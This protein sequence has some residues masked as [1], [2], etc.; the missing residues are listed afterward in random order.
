MAFSSFL[1]S[2]F[3]ISAD[4]NIYVSK[5]RL[6]DNLVLPLTIALSFIILV[7]FI[8]FYRVIS[9][10]N[11][12]YE[13]AK[14]VVGD[15][16][17]SFGRKMQKHDNRISLAAETVN[18]LSSEEGNIVRKMDQHERR[19]AE[20]ASKA[21]KTLQSRSKMMTEVKAIEEKIRQAVSVQETIEQKIDK[22][23]E[24]HLET[25]R[26]GR[27]IVTPISIKRER[28]LAS[29]TEYQLKILEILASEGEKTAPEMKD[30]IRITR[31]HTARLMRRLYDE[32]YVERD[33][34]KMPYV[35]RIK[36]EA[37]EILKSDVRD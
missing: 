21:E 16:T 30:K 10:A 17:I 29:L 13:K 19:L 11:E 22:L 32:G 1:C 3:L 18:R 37:R 5:V 9:E 25:V 12:E 15:I 27:K 8:L 36:E 31:E 14:S 2:S 33:M 23:E 7:V 20:I 34:R 4:D 6:L 35:Y 24:T 28:A 26:T